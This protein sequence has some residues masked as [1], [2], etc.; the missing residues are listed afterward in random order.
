[1]IFKL[2]YSGTSNTCYSNT[3]LPNIDGVLVIVERNLGKG[4]RCQAQIY[5]LLL[6][7]VRMDNNY[8]L[9]SL[10]MM[11]A[12]IRATTVIMTVLMKMMMKVLAMMKTV[13]MRI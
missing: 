9:M 7:D 8:M 6:F 13:K 3:I 2:F 5:S 10:T 12:L 11:T 1:M 4:F